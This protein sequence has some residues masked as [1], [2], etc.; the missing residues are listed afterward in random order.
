MKEIESGTDAEIVIVVRA[1]S[2]S[3]RHADYLFGALVAFV[4][5]LFLLFLPVDFHTYWV[6]IDI[7]V[8][9]GIGAYLSKWEQYNQTATDQQEVSQGI[10]ARGCRGNVL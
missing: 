10:S 3:Y 4:G 5:L 6:P 9:F 1:R 2:G 7:A 8:L